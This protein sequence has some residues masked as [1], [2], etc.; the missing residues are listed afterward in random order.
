MEGGPLGRSHSNSKELATAGSSST[1][2]WSRTPTSRHRQGGPRARHD[3]GGS[4]TKSSVQ[5]KGHRRYPVS[6][7]P[8]RQPRAAAISPHAPP[9]SLL[10]GVALPKTQD[11]VASFFE[12]EEK[13]LRA[14]TRI[15]PLSL[16]IDTAA[17]VKTTRP[18]SFTKGV[19]E[20]RGGGATLD[21]GPTLSMERYTPGMA[22]SHSLQLGAASSQVCRLLIGEASGTTSLPQGEQQVDAV[23]PGPA[24][25]LPNSNPGPM[26]LFIDVVSSVLGEAPPRSKTPKRSRSSPTPTGQSSSEAANTSTVPVSQR[27]M[28]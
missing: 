27:G 8:S 23:C 1:R 24:D 12:E 5:A 26:E 3:H 2:H 6:K 11:S 18:L 13:E 7:P 21:L 28:L 20:S 17:V 10:Q 4:T 22:T 14:P 16:A 9:R 25:T 15:D 19:E